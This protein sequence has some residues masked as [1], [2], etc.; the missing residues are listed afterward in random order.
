MQ[1]PRRRDDPRLLRALPLVLGLAAAVLA[2]RNL[3]HAHADLGI[4]LD[5]A[6]EL[7]QGGADIYRARP[8]SG[9]FAY[10]PCAAL[11]F[12]LLQACCSETA[13]RWLWSAGLGLATALLAADLRTALASAGGLRWWQ[14][15]AF[16][17][18]FQRCIA[19]NLTH[20]QLSLWVGACLLRG[21]VRLQQ[22]RDLG[23][24]AWLGAATALKL[25]PVV[26]VAALPLMG[27]SRAAAAMAGTALVL[28]LL[29]PWPLLG[30]AEHWRHLGDFAGHVLAPMAGHGQ[31][32]FTEFRAGPSIAGTLD[33][34]LQPRPADPEG[35]TANVLDVGDGA[36]AAIKLLWSLLLGLLLGGWFWRARRC[37][38]PLRLCEQSAAVMLAIAFFAPLT[39]VYHL[40]G[41]LLAFA[42][43]C[44]GPAGRRDW[45]WWL[46]A[47]G[48]L[49]AMTLRQRLLLGEALWR[50][51]DL[52]GLLHFALVGLT[53]WSYRH[54]GAAV[55]P[56]LRP[57][58]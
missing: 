20:G 10:P 25:T 27:R 30:T 32:Q 34:L 37:A 18:L 38:T 19:Q 2:L 3:L 49:L 11:P 17:V 21:V 8:E 46:T 4:Y 53:A 6:R 48:L 45:L 58:P 24:G 12:V 52:G 23:A 47:L 28:V 16:A 7:R 40:A 44:R 50:A 39:R 15:L 57:A 1:L 5:V 43:F 36:L 51:L 26:F 14:W 22:G 54:C 42:L 9:A 55:R 41:A 33:Y 56:A 29:L 13:S 35:H 31:T